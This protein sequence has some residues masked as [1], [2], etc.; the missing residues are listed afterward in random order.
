MSIRSFPSF[1]TTGP[2]RAADAD[3]GRLP[4][5]GDECQAQNPLPRRPARRAAR[6]GLP[7]VV[8]LGAGLDTRAAREPCPR[9]RLF[10][11]RRSEHGGVQANRLGERGVD[12]PTTFIAGNYVT[13]GVL[14]LLEA[15]GFDR[16]LP[17]FFIWEGNTMYLTEAGG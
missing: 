4:G 2:Q 17:S 10:R 1:S 6:R 8:I 3:F 5:G 16:D 13:A 14:P 9:R 15:N 12:A 7:Q 11:D